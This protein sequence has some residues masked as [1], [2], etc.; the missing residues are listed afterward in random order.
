[1]AMDSKTTTPM[2]ATGNNAEPMP[3]APLDEDPA[4]YM[5]RSNGLVYDDDLSTLDIPQNVLDFVSKQL[6]TQY[7]ILPIELSED[8]T[9]TLVTDSAESVKHISKIS[10]QL[11]HDIKLLLARPENLRP[12]LRSRYGIKSFQMN[13]M[14]TMRGQTELREE[15]IS[16]LRKKVTEMLNMLADLH[17][18][19]LHVLPHSN[20]VYVQMRINGRIQDFTD[21]FNFLP[22][23][24]PILVNI[25]KGLD[26]SNNADSSISNMPNSG[27]FQM[28]RHGVDID[29][30][31]A[32]VPVG[33]ASFSTQKVNVREMPQHREMVSLDSIYFG[34]DL[35]I[36]KKTLY[37]G[38]SGLFLMSGPVGTGK[39]TSLYAQISYL[40][41]LE[42]ERGYRL[43][44]F[45]IED[46]IEIRDER[47]TQ[48]Q[49]RL[50]QQEELSLTAPKAL[51]VALR[52]DPDIILYGEIR[53][54]EDADV[55]VKAS[56][57]GLKMF[58]TIHAGDC[59]RT[60][61]RL[62]DLNVSRM[63][64]LAELK[65]I[66]C[67]RLLAIL[68]PYCSHEHVLTEQEKSILSEDEIQMLTGPNVHLK[69]RGTPEERAK[70][71]HCNDGIRGRVAVPE[72]V[73][74]T[75]KLRD[76]LLKMNDFHTV[77]DLLKKGGFVSMWTKGLQIVAQGKAELSDV[78]AKIGKD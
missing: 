28:E 32:T 71:P 22:Q 24:G 63:S 66:I 23:D 4:V 42:E 75:P 55:A 18:S 43:N 15:D 72:Y 11:E 19:D 41:N 35:E 12:E 48:V 56:Q 8:G 54:S 38:G 57:T 73:I 17:G 70:C 65:L 52:S 37:K 61:N 39:S 26:T 64:L 60:I 58:S 1:M 77:Q 16:P 21:H 20:G 68:C 33:N 49:V 78:I 62:L 50:A 69:E 34:R 47:F 14:M 67:Q 31:L 9:L 45:C 27:S 30:R 59:I 10:Q 6:A 7:H 3:S 5:L 40:W 74:F 36:I 46:P 51:K 13:S 76:A 2:Q 44:V 53:D 25:F 29:C